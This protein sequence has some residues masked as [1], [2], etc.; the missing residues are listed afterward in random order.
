MKSHPGTGMYA[1]SPEEFILRDEDISPFNRA[2]AFR[3]LRDT[4]FSY[5]HCPQCRRAMIAL[6]HAMFSCPNGHPTLQYA[7]PPNWRTR[8]WGLF[9]ATPQ[10]AARE[11]ND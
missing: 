1:Q 4:P 8:L 9:I 6:D 10:I 7:S 3:A 5:P 11:E 2:G